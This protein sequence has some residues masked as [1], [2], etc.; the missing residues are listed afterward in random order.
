[1]NK[2]SSNNISK[3]IQTL[4]LL[5]VLAGCKRVEPPQDIK[6]NPNPQDKFIVT[7]HID[8]DVE[9]QELKAI[10]IFEVVNVRECSPKDKGQAI[11]GHW[12]PIEKFI[13]SNLLPVASNRFKTVY[14]PKMYLD[15]SYYSMEVCHWKGS[16]IEYRF[17]KNNVL[18]RFGIS[19][20][21]ITQS[22][23]VSIQ[24]ESLRENRAAGISQ[25]CISNSPDRFRIIS[26]YF[27]ISVNS[28]RMPK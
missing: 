8:S 16:G 27:V 12:N 13:E 6:V 20:S 25:T 9:I 24:C 3:I 28:K 2:N 15:E 22:S 7:V 21:D 17:S 5:I 10:K 23:Q 11:G 18:Y 1:M 4:L 14:Y 26:P 19:D